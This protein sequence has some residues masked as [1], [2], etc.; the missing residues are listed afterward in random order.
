MTEPAGRWGQPTEEE[1]A[2][3]L[4]AVQIAW[5]APVPNPAAIAATTAAAAEATAEA[6]SRWRF[7]GRWW[8]RPV[9]ARR[10][11]PWVDRGF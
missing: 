4:A 5:P 7:S 1:L 3:I 2:A 9:T 8:T 6:E 11:R 10:V